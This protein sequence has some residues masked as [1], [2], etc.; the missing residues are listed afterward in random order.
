MKKYIVILFLQLI[1]VQ[2]ISGCKSDLQN[3]FARNT[4]TSTNECREVNYP[5][6]F[7]L[8]KYLEPY[9]TYKNIEVF[10]QKETEVP[11]YMNVDLVYFHGAIWYQGTNGVI[12]NSVY[13]YDIET[14]KI[15]RYSLHVNGNIPKIYWHVSKEDVLWGI[16]GNSEYSMTHSMENPSILLRYN[17]ESDEFEYVDD[18]QNHFSTVFYDIDDKKFD[19][20][21]QGNLWFAFENN[22][23]KFD[24]TTLI[25]GKEYVMDEEDNISHIQI[26]DQNIVWFVDE[27]GNGLI[28][29]DPVNGKELSTYLKSYYFDEN[30]YN[31]E[32]TSDD[33]INQIRTSYLDMNGRLWM[34]DKGWYA[35]DEKNVEGGPVWYQIIRS[36]VFIT[37]LKTAGYNQAIW[38]IPE[39]IT[40]T[41]DGLMW[42]KGLYSFVKLN[43][44]TADWCRLK[45]DITLPIEDENK[46][47]WTI[48]YK[49]H[50]PYLYSRKIK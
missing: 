40:Q 41:S 8:G 37:P 11:G 45:Y 24:P 48:A 42:F 31:T 13:Q 35:L 16:I 33:N 25:M 47:I 2:F 18:K 22:L 1:C 3:V 49:E 30:T 15:T 29:Y 43:P 50:V 19:S 4:E 28:S 10:W 9:E 34:D 32:N 46:T 7:P 23:Y 27:T 17:M 44:E 12:K 36:P 14:K 39:Q 26:D 20:D 6:A 5:L 21:N 38:E